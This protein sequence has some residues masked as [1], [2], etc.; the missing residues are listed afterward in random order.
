MNK[1]PSANKFTPK[2]WSTNPLMAEGV[3]NRL[4]HRPRIAKKSAKSIG[5]LAWLSAILAGTF[6]ITPR[7]AHASLVA[8]EGF[9][10]TS[11]SANL[12]SQSG[13]FGWSGNWQGVNNGSSSV[14]ASCLVAGG[15]APV[16]YDALSAGNSAFTPNNT[17][18][19]R[20]LDV[21]AGGSFG[22]AGYL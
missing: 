2:N 7:A 20:Q 6:F 9:N 1:T 16:G 17:R 3:V 12:T 4:V 5:A 11:G 15:N 18:T 8:Y 19:G 21:S 14:Q 10:Y 22:L 13:G